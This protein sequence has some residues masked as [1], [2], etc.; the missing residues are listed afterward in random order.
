MANSWHQEECKVATLVDG[1]ESKVPGNDSANI[2]LIYQHQSP[3]QVPAL[4]Y[5]NG[6]D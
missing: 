6:L 5:Y 4:N 2:Q 1:P 3:V